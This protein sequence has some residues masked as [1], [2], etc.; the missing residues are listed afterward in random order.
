MDMTQIDFAKLVDSMEHM[1][2]TSRDLHRA[3]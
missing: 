1:A 3:A 2:Y